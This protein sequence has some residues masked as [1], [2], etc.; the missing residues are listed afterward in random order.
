MVNSNRMKKAELY[1]CFT[2][3]EL[4]RLDAIKSE[5]EWLPRD[6]RTVARGRHAQRPGTANLGI[7]IPLE[8]KESITTKATASGS[9]VNGMIRALLEEVFV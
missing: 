4:Q 8:L 3:E 7:K 9:T 5:P 2:V 6:K 1:D